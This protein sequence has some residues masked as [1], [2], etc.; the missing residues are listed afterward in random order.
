[1]TKFTIT[2]SLA[3]QDNTTE[4]GQLQKIIQCFEKN[5][6]L[7]TPQLTEQI[8]DQIEEKIKRMQQNKSLFSSQLEF[9]QS[10]QEKN[11]RLLREC[12]KTPDTTT[13]VEFESITLETD[14]ELREIAVKRLTMLEKQNTQDRLRVQLP[15][16]QK[17]I[18]LI[19]ALVLVLHALNALK[20]TPLRFSLYSEDKL[21]KRPDSEEIKRE[22]EKI[23][24]APL[25]EDLSQMFVPIPGEPYSLSFGP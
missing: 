20:E 18:L 13:N 1:M 22:Q 11:Q 9:I 14:R 19:D 17:N 2:N 21:L 12:K 25:T 5:L 3:I 15:S 4:V 24:I 8:F 16:R 6:Q 7:L 10:L 23:G